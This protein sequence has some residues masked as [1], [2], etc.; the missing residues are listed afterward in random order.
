M[1]T[2]SVRVDS[3]RSVAA[4][5][6]KLSNDRAM[7]VGDPVNDYVSV[8]VV[9]IK[10][11]PLMY[12][13]TPATNRKVTATVTNP[14]EKKRGERKEVT[15]VE[16]SK[17]PKLH[18]HPFVRPEFRSPEVS[19]RSISSSD[20]SSK[21]P[22]SRAA[23]TFNACSNKKTSPCSIYSTNPSTEKELSPPTRSVLTPTLS[24]RSVREDTTPKQEQKPKQPSLFQFQTSTPKVEQKGLMWTSKESRESPIRPTTKANSVKKSELQKFS[25][26]RGV[27]KES[28]KKKTRDL[29]PRVWRRVEY[30]GVHSEHTATSRSS[31]FA[32]ETISS[33]EDLICPTPEDS[34]KTTSTQVETVRS[35]PTMKKSHS[36]NVTVVSIPN[37]L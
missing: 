3:K 36:Q 14:K 12:K 9:N 30:G 19:P 17:K 28:A 35:E 5:K 25:L 26:A 22:T 32:Y 29:D 8:D 20:E 11:T 13:K 18:Y 7:K 6:P 4:V 15:K 34:L 33:Q 27:K 10:L 37:P 21:K 16:K 1:T 2:R 31:D 24:E 23:S